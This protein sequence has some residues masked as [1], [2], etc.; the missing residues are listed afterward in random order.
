MTTGTD[1]ETLDGINLAWF[2]RISRELHTGE[3][4]FRPGRRVLLPKPYG[5]IRPLGVASPRDKIVQ[6]AMRMVLDAVFG[7]NFSESSH[8]FRSNKSCHTALKEIQ[9]KFGGVNWFIE[10][11]ISKCFDTFN[12]NLLIKAVARRITDQPFLDLLYKAL[13]AGYIDPRG[14][15]HRHELG[16]PQGSTISP[17]LCNIYLDNLDR[18]VESYAKEFNTGSKRR[19]QNPEYT[20]LVR[21]NAGLS[22]EE[23]RK[24]LGFI[25][26]KGI[27]PMLAK[28]PSF[29]RLKYVRYADDF[30]IGVTGSKFDCLKVVKDL[31]QFLNDELKLRLSESKTKITHATTEKVRFLGTEIRLT[32]YNK[33]P[34]RKVTLGGE[35]ITKMAVFTP[36]FE[37]GAERRFPNLLAPIKDIVSK[38]CEKGFARKGMVGAPTR[39]G[40]FIHL[41]LADIVNIYLSIARGYINYYSFVSNYARFRARVIYIL[42]YS[43]ALTLASKLKLGTLKRVFSRFGP[44]ITVTNRLGKEVCFDPDSFPKSAPGFKTGIDYDPEKTLRLRRRWTSCPLKEAVVRFPRTRK[45]LESNCSICGSTE[46]LEVHHVRHL[47]K[48]GVAVKGD[49]LLSTMVKMNRKQITVCQKCHNNIHVGRYDGPKL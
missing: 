10:G 12:H 41:E 49:F 20:R 33:K 19:R 28:D 7:N 5:G 25:H 30:L 40:R 44:K 24:R 4:Q 32:P 23:R 22:Y 29:K 14:A 37:E 9:L 42:Q 2:K 15:F 36:R 47:R 16:T 46:K 31:R 17:I 21:G 18:W 34:V 35:Q 48:M 8:G 6:E 43:L 13:K 26:E 1:K 45:L 38:L 27:R 39:V 3:F 11:D